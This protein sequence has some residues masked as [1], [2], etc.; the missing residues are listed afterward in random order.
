MAQPDVLADELAVR[1]VLARV[2]QLA[3][4]G[5]LDEYLTLF[6]EDAS[7]AMP[8]V[9][10]RV[11]HADIRSGAEQ[12]R[13]SKLQGPGA[14]SRHVLTTTAVRLDGD[15]AT[16]RSYWM[17]LTNTAEQPTISLTGQYDDVLQ[18]VGDGWRLAQ[19]VITMG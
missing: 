14:H 11:G 17:F 15:Q 5:D 1:N 6:T 9:E 8:G 16:A 3:D 19:R 12:R 13:A 2:A 4:S 10:P 18:R 7:W